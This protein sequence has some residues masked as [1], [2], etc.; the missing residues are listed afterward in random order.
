MISILNELQKCNKQKP[1]CTIQESTDGCCKKYRCGA[2]LYFLPL[3]SSNFN[4]TIDRMIG[5]PGHGKYI[6]D[7]INTCDKRYL[8]EKC[9]WLELQKLMIVKKEWMLMQ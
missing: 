2:S 6:V 7:A 5:A 4:I 9:A 1:K 8:K 3:S